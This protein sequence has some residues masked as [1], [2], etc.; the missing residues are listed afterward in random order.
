MTQLLVILSPSCLAPSRLALNQKLTIYPLPPSSSPPPPQ[1][2]FPPT[3]S[4]EV[5]SV[6]DWLETDWLLVEDLLART[7][8]ANDQL[9]L[10]HWY[11]FFSLLALISHHISLMLSAYQVYV[12]SLPP[13]WKVGSQLFQQR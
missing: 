4:H 7:A 12:Y 5:D 1:L 2:P 13:G 3:P 6:F 8:A 11:I 10:T 9:P